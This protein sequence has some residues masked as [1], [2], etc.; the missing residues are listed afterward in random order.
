MSPASH[1]NGELHIEDIGSRALIR[2]LSPKLFVVMEDGIRGFLC[3]TQVQTDSYKKL[4]GTAF[5]VA[6]SDDYSGA[7][8][9]AANACFA[10][11]TGMVSVAVPK[12]IKGIVAKKVLNEVIVKT[13]ETTVVLEE[14]T[15]VVAIGCGL[16]PNEKTQKF[17]RETVRN[18]K[19]P[20]V[21]DAEALNA[22][23]PFDLKGSKDLPLVLTPHIGE[24]K[25]L[26]GKDEELIDR[27][28]AARDFPQKQN[29]ILVLK[30][31]RVLI[32]EPNGNVYINPNGNAGVSRAGA[33][34]TLTGVITGFLAQALALQEKDAEEEKQTDLEKAL[35][36]VLSAVYIAGLAGDIAAAKFGQRFTTA[37]DIRQCL[38]EAIIKI[39]DR[40][41]IRV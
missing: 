9:L 41:A 35:L 11:G 40:E 21:L 27:V 4:R 14:K 19:T 36:A 13:L 26:L 37:S 12:S 39:D 2:K 25:R 15:N 7:A 6:G 29:V 5:I 16:S 24:F 31:E 33:G 3:R 38:A 17:I 28:S 1:F 10:A 20:M 32:A 23:S 30:G 34:D 22:L 8:V 18:R